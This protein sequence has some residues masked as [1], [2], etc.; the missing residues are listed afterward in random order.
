[1]SW[2]FLI[3]AFV[4]FLIL[5]M[6]MPIIQSGSSTANTTMGDFTANTSAW[7]GFSALVL[8][9][10]WLFVIAFLIMVAVGWWQLRKHD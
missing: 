6:G 9:S 2:L 5:M 4:G 3:F 7:E 8:S 1:M 10:P